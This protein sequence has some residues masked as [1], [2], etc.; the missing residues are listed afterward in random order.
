MKGKI[1]YEQ[2]DA[3]AMYYTIANL[4]REIPKR[5]AAIAGLYNDIV[6]MYAMDNIDVNDEYAAWRAILQNDQHYITE[7]NEKLYPLLTTEWKIRV[8]DESDV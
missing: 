2:L 1:P 8:E 6:E 7:W 5:F 4:E 3:A